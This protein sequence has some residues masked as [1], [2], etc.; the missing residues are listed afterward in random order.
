MRGLFV[1]LLFMTSFDN[2]DNSTYHRYSHE[3]QALY[4]ELVECGSDATR[5]TI[6]GT[7]INVKINEAMRDWDLGRTDLHALATLVNLCENREC[8]P[9]AAPEIQYL[10]N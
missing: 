1:T 2:T 8:P 4:A 7:A 3:L 10:P 9:E 5:G 6:V